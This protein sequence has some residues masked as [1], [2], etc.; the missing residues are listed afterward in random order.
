[1]SSI[2]WA[3]FL[4]SPLFFA[5]L[6]LAKPFI[7][8]EPLI[9]ADLDE[10]YDETYD[11]EIAADDEEAMSFLADN[12]TEIRSQYPRGIIL[13]IGASRPWQW[14]NLGFNQDD[15]Q[16]TVGFGKDSSERI[17]D[18]ST[19][20]VSLTHMAVSAER[21]WFA[22]KEFPL[23]LTYGISYGDWQGTSKL[24]REPSKAYH[25]SG[26]IG[27]LSL[28]LHI[29]RADRWYWGLSIIGTS[30]SIIL[31]ESGHSQSG[32]VKRILEDQKNWGILNFAVGYFFE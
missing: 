4:V 24:N 14:L 23:A 3:F 5:N 32:K 22:V 30:R 19:T 20:S 6:S 18:S 1:L 10:T 28:G 9:L 27:L 31:S 11:E 16:V 8:A 7:E 25:A 26:L 15:N 21:R 13:S 2:L 17:F 12:S 29:Q